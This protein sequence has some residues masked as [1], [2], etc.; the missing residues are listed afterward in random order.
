MLCFWSYK[1]R[2]GIGAK[3]GLRGSHT[4]SRVTTAST[5][6]ARFRR[7]LSY[8][9]R[10][11]STVRARED[12]GAAEDSR[13]DRLAKLEAVL[14][15]ANEPLN[16]RKLA[17]YAN[18]ADGTEARTL[19]GRLNQL[20]DRTGCA[21]RVVEV[22][23]GMQLLTRPKFSAWLRR[24]QHVPAEVRLS[25]P[26]MEALAVVAYCQPVLRADIESVRGVGCGEILRQLMERDLVRVSGRSEELGRPYVYSTIKRF[27]QLFGLRSQ[28][29]LPRAAMFRKAEDPAQSDERAEEPNSTPLESWQ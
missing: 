22:A 2:L 13:D 29:D 4:S 20:Y 16:I 14:F 26:A 7:S 17:R 23:G 1:R 6:G 9:R 28:D 8:R 27:L 3:G 11:A 24:L 5:A 19:V 15:V 12:V 10:Q 18:L 25:A 21:F